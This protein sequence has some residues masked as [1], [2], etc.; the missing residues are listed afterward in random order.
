MVHRLTKNWKAGFQNEMRAPR[1]ALERACILRSLRFQGIRVARSSVLGQPFKY[2][3]QMT[4][5][6]RVFLND[7]G[8]FLHAL[9]YPD[10]VFQKAKQRRE[11]GEDK[12]EFAELLKQDWLE[13]DLCSQWFECRMISCA[14]PGWR[15]LAVFN[16]DKDVSGQP[17]PRLFSYQP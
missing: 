3:R 9:S 15:S 7:C 17:H 4:H 6:D 11:S 12:R 10:R 14:E 16:W 2:P 8:I 5:Y 1:W 13:S